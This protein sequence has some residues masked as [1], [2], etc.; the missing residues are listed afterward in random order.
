MAGEDPPEALGRPISPWTPRALADEARQ[1]GIVEP[2]S[3]RHVG[4]VLQSGR[5]QAPQKPLLAACRAR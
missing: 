5:A 1:R 2:I 3:E 4:R